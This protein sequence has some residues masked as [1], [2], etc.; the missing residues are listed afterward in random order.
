M[1]GPEVVVQ[2][3]N[4]KWYEPHFQIKIYKISQGKTDFANLNLKK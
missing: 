4:N 2:Q 1:A 3:T